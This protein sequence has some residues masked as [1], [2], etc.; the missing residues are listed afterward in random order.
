VIGKTP[1]KY[2]TTVN[3]AIFFGVLIINTILTYMGSFIYSLMVNNEFFMKLAP[4]NKYIPF[5]IFF[6]LNLYGFYN[7][8]ITHNFE[9]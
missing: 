2:R 9:I 3:S 5:L 7:M 8:K 4:V 6:G 1:Y